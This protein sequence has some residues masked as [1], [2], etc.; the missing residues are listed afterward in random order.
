[1]LNK[2]NLPNPQSLFLSY[3]SSAQH[4]SFFYSCFQM[5]YIFFQGFP[6]FA[7]VFP[8]FFPIVFLFLSNISRVS[9]F[10][11]NMFHFFPMFSNFRVFFFLK[12]SP[13]ALGATAQASDPGPGG[14][15]SD[16]GPG[17]PG[18]SGGA[19]AGHSQ[20]QPE[21][22]GSLWGKWWSNGFLVDFDTFF[23]SEFW[24][25]FDFLVVC[26]CYCYNF[27]RVYRWSIMGTGIILVVVIGRIDTQ[28]V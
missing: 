11:S 2:I 23:R 10:L 17:G 3:C 18:G 25:L 26:C 14:P 12:P 9:L 7:H 5:F 27:Q 13:A 16:P 28:Y 1:M 19:G 21:S 22:P 20:G 8:T 24:V 4:L 6:S 15:G